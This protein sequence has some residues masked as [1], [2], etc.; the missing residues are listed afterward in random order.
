MIPDEFES[1]FSKLES[2][3]LRDREGEARLRRKWYSEKCYSVLERIA[4]KQVD[5]RDSILIPTGA[6]GNIRLPSERNSR[7]NHGHPLQL[8]N[9]T[10]EDRNSSDDSRL[11]NFTIS[12]N[13]GQM[14]SRM[15]RRHGILL[16]GHR[17]CLTLVDTFLY[18]LV[19]V[20]ILTHCVIFIYQN[21]LGP[22]L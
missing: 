19:S 5:L 6:I 15:V 4:W 18:I 21:K 13:F 1:F 2:E 17:I 22:P 8:R 3:A 9:K 10:S 20:S 11:N 7:Q 12:R 14:P 16:F